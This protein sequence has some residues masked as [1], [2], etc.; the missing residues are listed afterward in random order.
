MRSL[1]VLLAMLVA[2]MVAAA[3][4]QAAFPGRNGGIA[5]AQYTTSGDLDPTIS[6]H[7]RLLVT[8]PPFGTDQRRTLVDCE[9]LLPDGG[10]CTRM[11]FRSPSY[12]PDGERIVFDAG[13]RLAIIDADGGEPVLQ[14]A[15]TADDGDPCFS[16]DGRRIAFTGVND[17]G[18]TDLYVRA[19][20]GGTAHV[21]IYD[22]GEPAWSSTR[23]GSR[24][25][26]VETC[27]PRTPAA[28]LAAGSAPASR[29]TGRRT[30]AASRSCARRRTSPSTDRT[31]ACTPWP[32][33]VATSAASGA[34]GPF[35]P[36]RLVSG[37]TL[38]RVR[39][40]RP[41]HLRE[42]VGG[43]RRV[44]RGRDRPTSAARA[45]RSA[46]ST[47]PGGRAD[48]SCSTD[49]TFPAGSLNHA[50]SGPWPRAMPFRPG[51][52]RRTCSNSTPRAV[53]SSTAAS[54]SSTGKF[55]I[56]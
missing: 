34:Q 35:L 20:G 30:A 10:E 36:S 33:A 52:S 48:H 56:V 38:A 24:T 2:L 17:H 11:G 39:A 8:R 29:R 27:T 16:P 1:T 46:R 18:G 40:L 22:A 12:S 19:L 7:A 25:C 9:V 32:R 6:E 13:A 44:A 37:W 28:A 26:A 5:F 51:R 43:R 49:R 14:A 4:A 21:I 45:A 41:R 23:T 53:S 47:R 42:A 55:R 15:A 3:S 31:A 54:T 50:M